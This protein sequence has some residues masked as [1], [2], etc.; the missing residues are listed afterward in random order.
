MPPEVRT[1]AAFRRAR[2]AVPA[3][4]LATKLDMD[5]GYL[6][7]LLPL[8][9]KF[10]KQEHKLHAVKAIQLLSGALQS[11]RSQNVAL[12]LPAAHRDELLNRRASGS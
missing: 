7:V 3:T 2:P 10:Q 9:Q 1:A 4:T 12:S 5:G 11:A 8:L 6:E